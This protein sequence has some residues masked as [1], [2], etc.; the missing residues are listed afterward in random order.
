M[1]KLLLSLLMAGSAAYSQSW[2]PQATGFPDQSRGILEL[3]IVDANTVWCLAYDGAAGGAE[4]LQEFTKTTDGGETWTPGFVEMFDPDLENQQLISSKR[5]H[6]FCKRIESGL[7]IGR[8][9]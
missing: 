4:F 3:D 7:G 8:R 9:L 6:R 1:K 2:V 5:R